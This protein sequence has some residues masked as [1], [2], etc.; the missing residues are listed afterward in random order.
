MTNKNFQKTKE[1]LSVLLL[2]IVLPTV[3]VITDIILV[4]KLY[5]VNFEC[6]VECVSPTSLATAMMIP[7][8]V[9]YLVCF[10]NWF[11][12]DQNKKKT[13]LFPLLNCY[14]QYGKEII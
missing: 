4:V 5:T 10:Y 9:N 6:K 12:L 14:P 8:L 1:L 11:R 7:C 13:L 3:D 2:S